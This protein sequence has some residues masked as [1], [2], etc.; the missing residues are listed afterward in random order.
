M[1]HF[2]NKILI[3]YGKGMISGII[4]Y[5]SCLY[6]NIVINND[7]ERYWNR[8]LHRNVL[9]MGMLGFY[10]GFFYSLYNPDTS[11]KCIIPIGYRK[12]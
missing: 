12:Y 7:D 6:F 2:V 11:Y 9:C 5:T 4:T 10:G 3:S 8:V 1:Y